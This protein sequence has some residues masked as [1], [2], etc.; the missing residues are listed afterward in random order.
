MERR[1]VEE[2]SRRIGAASIAPSIRGQARAPGKGLPGH[3]SQW[4][5]WVV[6]LTPL[7]PRRCHYCITLQAL[8]S[9]ESARLVGLTATALAA[10]AAAAETFFARRPAG[11]VQ[12]EVCLG[13]G[14][15]GPLC[16]AGPSVGAAPGVAGLPQLPGQPSPALAGAARAA[17]AA[18]RAGSHRSAL[19]LPLR[20]LAGARQCANGWLWTSGPAPLPAASGV[21]GACC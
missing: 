20:L 8:T 5:A 12:R 21:P 1:C 14:Q 11:P 7:L 10:A 4:A 2:D 3:A 9:T 18:G 15:G 13:A 16:T 17:G 19:P 6:V